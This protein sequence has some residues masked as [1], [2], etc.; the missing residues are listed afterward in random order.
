[1]KPLSLGS[2]I[3]VLSTAIVAQAPAPQPG[4]EH[5]RLERFAGTWKLE[6]KMHPSPLGQ[7]GPF[8]GTET[9]RMFEGGFHL[10]CDS[11]GTGPMGAMNGHAIMSWDAD[12]KQYRYF[13]INSQMPQP[14]EATGTVTGDTWTWTGKTDLGGGKSI[15]SRFTMVEESPTVHKAKWEVSQDGSS[16]TVVMEGTSTKTGS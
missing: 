7:G 9:C 2:L 5:K 11:T 3:V 1:M 14:E 13:A 10:T 16:W 4:P 15:N 8:T 6:G 12:A